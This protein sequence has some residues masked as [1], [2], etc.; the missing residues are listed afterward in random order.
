MFITQNRFPKAS[1]RGFLFFWALHVRGLQDKT[2]PVTID[3]G[4]L[5]RSSNQKFPDYSNSRPT[6]G[7]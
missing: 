7:A 1:F 4:A 3:R 5:I 2:F 6:G